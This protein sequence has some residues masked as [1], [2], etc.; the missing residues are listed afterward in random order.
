MEV[1]GSL[2]TTQLTHKVII[3]TIASSTDFHNYLGFHQ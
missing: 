1:S 3:T 2:I